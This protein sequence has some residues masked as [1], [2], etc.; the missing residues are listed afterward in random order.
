MACKQ[1]KERYRVEKRNGHGAATD[2]AKKALRRTTRQAKESFFRKRLDEASSS[3][4]IFDIA[5]WHKSV[6][7]F[8]SPPLKDPLRP[9]DPLATSPAAKRDVLARNLLQNVAEAGDIPLT[10]PAVPTASLPFPDITEQ[11]IERCILGAG[12]TTPGQDEIPTP[13]LRIGWPYLKKHVVNLF[14]ACTREGYHPSCFRTA[15]LAILSKPNKADKSSPRAYRPIAL[16]SVLGKGL[17]RLLA[18]RMSWIAIKFKVLA[19]QQFGALPLRSS[20][21]LTTCLTQDI[22]SAMNNGLTAS[23]LTLDVKGAFDTVL[24][25]RLV[26]RLR[27]QGWPHH[28]CNWVASFATSRKVCIRLDGETGEERKI[29]CGLPQGSPISP[30][31]FM[32]YISPLFSL[33]GL[34][35]GFGYAD[36][37]ASC[38]TSPSLEENSRALSDTLA[39]AL[40]WG[41]SEGIAF[42]PT[43][44]ELLH[45]SR[46]R[47]DRGVSP[48]VQ[49]GALTVAENADRPYL[50]WLG[51]LFDRKLTFKYHVQAQTAKAI[52]TARAFA[53]FGNTLRGVAASLIRQAVTACVLPIAYFAAETWWPGR[54]KRTHSA[55]TSNRV[56]K[57]LRLL[58]KV[59]LTSARAILPVFST[60]PSAVLLRESGLSPPE[61]KLEEIALR[62]TVRIRRLDAQ[63]PLRIRADAVPGP[64]VPSRR[65]RFPTRF[66]RRLLLL[67]CSEQLDMLALPPWFAEENREA[68][69]KRIGA[70]D[71]ASSK[72]ERALAFTQFINL[73]PEN[74]VI[75]YSDGSKLQDGQA[76]AG[77]A[78]TQFR[79][80]R[81]ESHPL[82]DSAEVFDAEATAALLGA[83]AALLLPFNRLAKDLWVCLDNLEVAMRLLS[84]SLTSSQSVFDSFMKVREAWR[85]RDTIFSGGDIYIRWVPGHTGVLGNELADAE[86]RNGSA[87]LPDFPLP[88]SFASLQRWQAQ[89]A[90]NAR[91][92]WWKSAIHVRYSLLS[93][94]TAPVPPEELGLSRSQLGRIIAARTQHGDFAD[95]HERFNHRDAELYCSCGARKA[96]FHFLFCRIARKHPSGTRG[97]PSTLIPELLGTSKGIA[98]LIQWWRRNRFY[99][100]TCPYRK[101]R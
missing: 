3:R 82:G 19:P 45:F 96:P 64:F 8:R 56:D 89:Q 40:E 91:D 72:E 95:Y 57:L 67:P 18:K 32:L 36:D 46:R 50:K 52:K 78:I 77:F 48:T 87:L 63:H 13:I 81:R 88:L 39:R 86:A 73:I 16:L 17:E 47:S 75:V 74:D 83:K 29:E 21:D 35:D 98:L 71:A 4:D 15:V 62:A 76:G 65:N 7:S 23:V 85:N 55:V 54:E 101:A 24:P 33:D 26:R 44:S 59:T 66:V 10:A 69:R 28:L 60:T 68:V 2:E 90:V 99:Q 84:H 14:Q 11:E 27:E 93:I 79:T 43:K 31:L 20:V 5:K 94:T 1:A 34:R 42:D 58:G 49:A 41:R 25:G 30:I 37:V 97:P 22:E 12:N 61:L 80:T 51:I 9:Q 100:D 92:R 6:G 70:P 38:K 53:S